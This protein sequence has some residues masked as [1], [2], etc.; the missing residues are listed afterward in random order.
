M[1]HA[2]RGCPI[3]LLPLLAPHSGTFWHT[4]GALEEASLAQAPL[5]PPPCRP[6]APPSRV[7]SAGCPLPL[8]HSTSTARHFVR[9]RTGLPL[10]RRRAQ[11]PGLAAPPTS[12]GAK[13][14][15]PAKM[16]WLRHPHGGAGWRTQAAHRTP[17]S[18]PP[19]W[20]PIMLGRTAGG[21]RRYRSA[22]SHAGRQYWAAAGKAA[23]GAVG[24]PAGTTDHIGARTLAS[25]P[26]RAAGSKL[27]RTLR[28]AAVAC[29][30][31]P[32]VALARLPLVVPCDLCALRSS[33]P[34][35]CAA[36][37]SGV[38]EFLIATVF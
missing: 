13:Q 28:P 2:G 30:G 35:R 12:C 10:A 38:Q 17:S 3:T 4:G 31:Y 15:C 7:A 20:L 36:C 29:C 19:S 14:G 9:R 27:L 25:T 5:P 34:P 26:I 23:A 33:C 24:P 16:G 6:R 18:G 32:E 1:P 11:G 21:S 8:L 37:A 22:Q